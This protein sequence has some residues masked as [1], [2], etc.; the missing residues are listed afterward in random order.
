MMTWT[1]YGRRVFGVSRTDGRA[2][3]H[4]RNENMRVDVAAALAF[5]A[6]RTVATHQRQ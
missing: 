3:D 5:R 6:V 2:L 4:C 1:N